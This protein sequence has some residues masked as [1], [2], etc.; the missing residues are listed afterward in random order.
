MKRENFV[1]VLR[2][3]SAILKEIGKLSPRVKKN[4]KCLSEFYELKR[5]ED[6]FGSIESYFDKLERLEI[7]NAN[8]IEKVKSLSEELEE[9]KENEEKFRMSLDLNKCPPQKNE[10]ILKCG[11]S[12]KS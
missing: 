8:L 10:K 11:N 1:Q 9:S 6:L 3:D 12:K 5:D 4:L 2:S 7:E